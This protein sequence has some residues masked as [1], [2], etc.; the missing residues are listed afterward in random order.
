MSGLVRVTRIALLAT[1]A[2]VAIG[3]CLNLGPLDPQVGV[4]GRG[5]DAGS[6]TL[7]ST[8]VQR[9][10]SDFLSAQGSTN[11]FVPPVPDFIGW[12]SAFANPPVHFASVDYAGLAAQW[13]AANGGPVLGTQMSGTVTERPLPDGTAEVHVVLKTTRAL[14]WAFDIAD[15]SGDFLNVPLLF[16]RRAQD[17]AAD[18]DLVPSLTNCQLDLLFTNT[19]PGAPLPDAVRAFILGE[20]LPGQSLIRMMFRAEGRGELRAHFGVEDGAAGRIT[21]VQTGLLMTSFKGATADAFPA[22]KVEL[23]VVRGGTF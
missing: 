17:L 18:P 10:L 5:P 9:P 20:A 4:V 12:A 22:E 7:T 3:G 14:T 1:L 16:G 15:F 21:V 23:R 13:L 11:I 6:G 8:A 19:A 2:L